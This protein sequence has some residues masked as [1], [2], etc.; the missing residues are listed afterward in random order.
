MREEKLNYAFRRNSIGSGA[1]VR[2]S[3]LGNEE[4]YL[5]TEFKSVS[6]KSGGGS[7]ATLIIFYGYWNICVSVWKHEHG[8][9]QSQSVGFIYGKYQLRTSQGY[10][11]EAARPQRKGGLPSLILEL[12]EWS[13]LVCLWMNVPWVSPL[14]EVG[15]AGEILANFISFQ[16]DYK[17]NLLGRGMQ[18]FEAGLIRS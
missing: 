18:L 3:R 14:S 2:L 6:K 4:K 10:I 12:K 16:H 8:I 1:R 15:M 13:E 9:R 17:C 7:S 11:W 5:K